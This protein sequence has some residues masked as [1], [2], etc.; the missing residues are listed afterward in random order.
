MPEGLVNDPKPLTEEER[1]DMAVDW[2]DDRSDYGWSGHQMHVVYEQGWMRGL[3]Y[4][5][6]YPGAEKA[7]EVSQNRAAGAAE[8]TPESASSGAKLSWHAWKNP[9]GSKIVSF[10]PEFTEILKNT[11]DSIA[12]DQAL[13]IT[14]IQRSAMSALYNALLG[15][16][17]PWEGGR[18]DFQPVTVL[19]ADTL[20][21][22]A[23]VEEERDALRERL[24][25]GGPE[26]ASDEEELPIEE[27]SE[28]KLLNA[29]M[30]IDAERA[31]LDRRETN[32]AIAYARMKREE[33]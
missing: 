17:V 5:R 28:A 23:R 4:G 6:R 10:G 19:P 24:D 33:F 14:D 1:G 32:A 11:A 30:R 31:D 20:Q 8:Q 12:I 26:D 25:D 3:T 13:D 21:R 27:W 15:N 29:L 9:D 22:L 18:L 7:N 2:S 16:D